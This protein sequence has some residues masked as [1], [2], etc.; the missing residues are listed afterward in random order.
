MYIALIQMWR[1]LFSSINKHKYIAIIYKTLNLC[2]Y[3]NNTFEVNFRYGVAI[4][5][6]IVISVFFC[7]LK[8]NHYYVMCNSQSSRKW[9]RFTMAIART[10]MC[11]KCKTAKK[12]N[13]QTKMQTTLI[14]YIWFT[15]CNLNAF[16]LFFLFLSSTSF[17]TFVTNRDFI[18]I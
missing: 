12:L 8:K 2:R 7:Q 5:F 3:K 15:F 11:E 14:R 9:N 17:A 6:D 1:K 4:V 10:M 18:L 13:F 16:P